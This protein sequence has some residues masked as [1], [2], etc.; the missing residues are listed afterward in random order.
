MCFGTDQTIG[1]TGKYMG[2]GQQS[3]EHDTV[4]VISPFGGNA[5]VLKLV[6]KVAQGNSPRDGEAQLYHDNTD[7]NDPDQDKG[8]PLS[9]ICELTAS[10]SKSTCAVDFVGNLTPVDSLSVFVKT[11]TGSFEG[12]TACVLIDPDGA[13]AP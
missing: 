3:G 10:P 7:N 11:D 12:A 2:L 6:V 4:G 8:S 1:N 5:Q 9:P 13:P